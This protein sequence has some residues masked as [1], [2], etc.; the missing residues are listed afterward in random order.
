MKLKHIIISVVSAFAAISVPAS[1]GVIGMADLSIQSF[2]IVDMNHAGINPAYVNIQGDNR[3]G[4]ATSTFNG[5][6]GTGIGNNELS[7][8]S[9]SGSTVDVKYRCAGPDCGSVASYYA[10]GAQPLVTG[11]A[12]P[13]N[14]LSTHLMTPVGNFALG[15]MLIGG[16]ALSGP[17]S[18]GLTRADSSVANAV[19]VATANATIANG[20]Q[21]TTST[22][23][24]LATTVKAEFAVTY[25]AF[26]K[27]FLDANSSGDALAAISW[28]LELTQKVGNKFVSVLKWSPDAI[29]SRLAAFDPSGSDEYSSAGTVFSAPVTFLANTIYKLNISQSS[30]SRAADAADVPEPASIFLIGLGLAGLGFAR[31]R[32]TK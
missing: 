5:V 2:A 9:I 8:T 24:S 29:N 31:R 26:T 16:S 14:D 20:V 22:T 21:A 3:T 27:V 13:E 11:G 12:L 10:G 15:D 28:G 17:G 18:F 19:N 6:S 32:Q 1:A 7:G 25:D 4:N 30:N 23:F